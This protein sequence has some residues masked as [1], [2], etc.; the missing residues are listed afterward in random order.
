M[1]DFYALLSRMKN[2]ERWSLMR[3]NLKENV[4]EHSATVA[5]IAH[6]LGIINN[7]IFFGHIDADKLVT[8]SVFHEAGEVLTGDLPT[9]IKYYNSNIRNA[10]KDIEA[11]ACE[12]LIGCLPA[13]FQPEYEAVLNTDT[14]S[15]EYKLLKAADKLGAYIKCVEEV[16]SG[17][18]EF[19]NAKITLYNSVTSTQLKEVDYFIEN[20]L[21]SFEK[22]L[23][24]I[25][26]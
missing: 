8:M 12:K 15:Y 6:A 22:N 14:N 21:P 16:K 13:E 7:K 1:S 2:I 24:N 4:M 17:N 26:L 10:Y 20:F 9:P 23:D 25:T 19:N 18:Y 5:I 11:L 3:C